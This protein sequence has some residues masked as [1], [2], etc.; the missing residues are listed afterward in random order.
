MT[1]SWSRSVGIEKRNNFNSKACSKYIAKID[2]DTYEANIRGRKIIVTKTKNTEHSDDITF[3]LNKGIN[4][5]AE[6][7]YLNEMKK[8][9][10]K[11]I[12]RPWS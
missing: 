1:D 10:T 3:T 6:I 12:K 4:K 2:K 7:I 8:I 5:F 11:Q 9:S